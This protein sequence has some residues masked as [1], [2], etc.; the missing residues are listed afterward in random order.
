[1]KGM[2]QLVE[3]AAGV[4]EDLRSK[5]IK[6]RGGDGRGWCWWLE[7]GLTAPQRPG[8]LTQ[9]RR[10]VTTSLLPAAGE[11]GDLQLLCPQAYEHRP[12]SFYKFLLRH[13]SKPSI[14][15]TGLPPFFFFFN[16][17]SLKP[18]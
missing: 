17:Q 6:A 12:F 7:S 13:L 3:R 9:L 15:S 8:A 4:P 18:H 2:S 11:A 5:D 16:L 1:M 14:M 10:D